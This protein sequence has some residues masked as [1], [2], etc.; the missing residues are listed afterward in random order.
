MT[1]Q[2]VLQIGQRVTIPSK[3]APA[4]PAI[5]P[6]PA[7]RIVQP[8]AKASTAKTA[9]DAADMYTIRSGDTVAKIAAELGVSKE[10]LIELNGLGKSPSLQVGKKLLIPSK[11]INASRSVPAPVAGGEDF[12]DNF[13]EIPVIE[14][15]N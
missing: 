15:K 6:A 14:I 10:E 1:D 2:D 4:A 8:P 3:T 12:F 9:S 11:K 13:E 5:K 7:P